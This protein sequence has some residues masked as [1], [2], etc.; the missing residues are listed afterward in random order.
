MATKDYMLTTID[1][2]FNPFTQFDSWL[3]FDIDKGY[4]TCAFIARIA[5]TSEQLSENEN[6]EEI[7]RA[8]DEIF[9]YDF[10]NMYKKVY[11][12]DEIVPQSLGTQ[13]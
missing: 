9:Q 1:N 6:E 2:P 8:I 10:M 12:N 4:N 5:R 3:N 11:R 13:A 7:D